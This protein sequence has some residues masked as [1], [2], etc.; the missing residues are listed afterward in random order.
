[1]TARDIFGLILRLLAV[2]LFVWGCWNLIAAL[3]YL[4]ATIQA[5]ISQSTFAYSSLRYGI[6]GAPATVFGILVLRFADPIVRFTYR[7]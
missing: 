3:F 5:F 1:M 4:P 6:Y 2:W 7:S